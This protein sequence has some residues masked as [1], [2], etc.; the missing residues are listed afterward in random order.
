MIRN[1]ASSTQ[2]SVDKKGH[3]LQTV[4]GAKSDTTRTSHAALLAALAHSYRQA[5]IKFCGGGRNNRSC[6]QIYRTSCRP[7]WEPTREFRYSLTASSMIYSW[8]SLAWQPRPL[9]VQMQP[10]VSLFLRGLC[11]A[12]TL[13][14]GDAYTSFSAATTKRRYLLKSVQ[15]R[16]L[17]STVLRLFTSTRS[18]A[19]QNMAKWSQLKP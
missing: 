7:V 17:N 1:Q 14:C 2:F 12:K 3:K 9:M 19:L 11:D 8:T 18:S 4:A 5:G 6:K 10:E 15:R 16:C 13:T